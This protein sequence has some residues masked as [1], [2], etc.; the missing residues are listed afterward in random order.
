MKAIC[1]A[2]TSTLD[3]AREEKV[4]IPHQINWAKNLAS[5]R[6]WE[7][8]GEYI[9]PGVFGD[10]EP[11]D[12][13]AFNKLWHDAKKG[14]FDVVMVY[15]S[16]RFAR[17]ADIGMKMCRILG[18]LKIQTY[19]R[20]SPIEPVN[21]TKF[22]W[23][24]NIGGMYMTAFSFIGDF[25]ENVARSER[26]RSGFQGLASRGVL[27]FAPYGYKKIPL[28]STD[29]EGRQRY[30]WNYEVDTPKALI[31]TRIFNS[32]VKEGGSLRQIM[33]NLNKELIPSPSGKIGAEGWSTTTI[34][35]I[36]TDPAYIGMVRWGRKLG[37]K[38]LQGKSNTGKQKR[39]FAKDDKLILTKS[40]NH[41]GFIEE[42]I[43]NQIQQKLNLRANLKGR[44]VA[45]QGLLTG[46]VKCGRCGRKAYF[47]HHKCHGYQRESYTCSSY[48]MYKSCQ[49]HIMSA[50]KLH[51][52]VLSEIERIIS[53]PDY[54][55]SLFAKKGNNKN[56]S[57]KVQLEYSHRALKEIEIS[58][59]RLLEA[60]ESGA[61]KKERY[62]ERAQVLDEKATG[63]L[64]EIEKI[65]KILQD[66]TQA[67]EARERFELLLTSFKETFPNGTF[68][69]QKD[70]LQSLIESVVVINPEVNINFRV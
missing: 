48:H 17:E 63:I 19:F 68:Q 60:L 1:Y 10:I 6:D 3:Q 14:S 22:S 47:K 56:N 30:T 49:R 27:T 57:L 53:N 20:N 38:Y 13:N 50:P 52:I 62:A 55:K 45:S 31:V 26:V 42:H 43:F 2:R 35:N 67:E 40:Q 70:W 54:R 69:K 28:I 15:H 21:P 61:L 5:E 66:T 24:Q 36:L 59:K 39:I 32:Y 46:L 44:A 4:S 29:N 11:E 8:I 9:E 12:R 64:N 41:Q 23:G 7:F 51:E 65:N 34:R 33:L 16:S 58:H 18:Q 25:Q 37:G